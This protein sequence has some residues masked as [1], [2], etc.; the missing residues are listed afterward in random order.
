VDALGFSDFWCLKTKTLPYS[1]LRHVVFAPLLGRTPDYV[2]RKGAPSMFRQIHHFHL[3][4]RK[5]EVER[6]P[7][8]RRSKILEE[9]ADD[10]QHLAQ[11]ANGELDVVR[12]RR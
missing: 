12:R 6:C 10:Y 9:I 5:L 8:S 11:G 3:R 1:A 4:S 7:D 2:Q